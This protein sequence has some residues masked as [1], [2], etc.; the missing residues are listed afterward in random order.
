MRAILG[1]SV[2][3]SL[4]MNPVHRK[5]WLEGRVNSAL[6]SHRPVLACRL[7]PYFSGYQPF[8]FWLPIMKNMPVDTL[9]LKN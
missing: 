9:L 2:S 8:A 5:V 1:P 6:D 4:C 3:K 7:I